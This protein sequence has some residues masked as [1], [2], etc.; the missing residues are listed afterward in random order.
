MFKFVTA[1]N[2][3]RLLTGYCNQLGLQFEEVERHS[4]KFIK[5]FENDKSEI[6]VKFVRA[7]KKHKERQG[8]ES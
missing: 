8:H 1:W 7:I 3:K 2:A 6:I 4:D 5:L